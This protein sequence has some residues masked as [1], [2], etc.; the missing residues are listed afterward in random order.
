VA[1]RT[2]MMEINMLDA[3]LIA[4]TWPPAPVQ[5]AVYALLALAMFWA[6]TL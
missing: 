3:I 5:G 1:C 4:A 6:G 2:L